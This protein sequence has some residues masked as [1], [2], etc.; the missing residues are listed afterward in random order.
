[1]TIDPASTLLALSGEIASYWTAWMIPMAWQ[2]TLL[3]LVVAAADRLLDRVGWMELRNGLWLLVALKLVLPPGLAGPWSLVSRWRARSPWSG[4]LDTGGSH[5][6]E[7]SEVV[8]AAPPEVLNEIAL[9]LL[10][11][12]AIGAIGTLVATVRRTRSFTRTMTMSAR[13]PSPQVKRIANLAARDIGVSAPRTLVSDNARAPFVSGLFR[14]TIV[15]PEEANR[16]SDTELRH[17]L[18][19]EMAHVRRHDLWTGSLFALLSGLYWFHPLV[20]LASQRAHRARE[21]AADAHVARRLGASASDY[22]ATLTRLACKT[23][24][25]AHPEALGF[26]GSKSITMSRLRALDRAT[27]R[28]SPAQTAS[29]AALLFAMAIIILPMAPHPGR[30]IA[31]AAKERTLAEEAFS[32]IAA[33]RTQTGSLHYRYAV[34]RLWAAD[35]KLKQVQRQEL[36]R[37]DLR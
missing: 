3:V 14:S 22:Q 36:D 25:P 29:A 10:A 31:A 23:L 19:H 20:A 24:R 2:A 26:L 15:L 5:R 30:A 17:V 18:L 33:D 16:W 28:S 37:G 12:W 34:L 6:I 13:Q 27:W 21:L 32:S 8:P 7:L 1:M 35:E 4:T 11:I 9:L